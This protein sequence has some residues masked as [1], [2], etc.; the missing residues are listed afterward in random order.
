MGPD[1][2]YPGGTSIPLPSAR[3]WRW[4]PA[5][6]ADGT[7]IDSISRGDIYL[8][9]QPVC[10]SGPHR[11]LGLMGPGS[12][13]PGTLTLPS[14]CV[15]YWD[16]MGSGYAADQQWPLCRLR[17]TARAGISRRRE[18]RQAARLAEG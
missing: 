8:P 10:D 9:L 7:R 6:L 17:D 1:R 2:H 11:V 5:P 13:E 12:K 3:V 15:G 14:G 18:T 16:T 4:T